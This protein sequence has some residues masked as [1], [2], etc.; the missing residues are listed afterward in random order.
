[1]NLQT[2][3]FVLSCKLTKL[4]W[5]LNRQSLLLV[6]SVHLSL[7]VSILRLT[8]DVPLLASLLA[9]GN[10]AAD[11]KEQVNADI[12]AYVTIEYPPTGASHLFAL[13]H[14][15]LLSEQLSSQLL[16][17]LVNQVNIVL[18]VTGIG[19]KVLCRKVQEAYC[20]VQKHQGRELIE[21]FQAL[22]EICLVW[23]EMHFVKSCNQVCQDE[24]VDLVGWPIAP[25]EG[26]VE[27]CEASKQEV[28]WLE[29]HAATVLS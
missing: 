28:D 10:R 18:R 25:V 22:Q 1:M 11:Q 7:V 9:V 23:P 6:L 20:L 13:Q 2:G 26:D 19:I 17:K 16:I 24:E 29:D 4:P 12:E 27:E 8:R 15:P 14:E 3:K 5:V 21:D